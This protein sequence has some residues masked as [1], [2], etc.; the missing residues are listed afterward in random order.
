MSIRLIQATEHDIQ[1]LHLL[2]C[3]SY[4]HHFSHLWHSA[5]ELNQYLDA[6]YGLHAI[7]QSMQQ[8]NVN[9]FVIK[10]D[11]A[12][13]LVKLTFAEKLPE[14]A[15][16][17]TM[18]NKIYFLPETT[19]QGHGQAIFKEIEDLARQQGDQCIWLEVLTSNQA[20]K[21][22][23]EKCGMHLV[24]DAFFIVAYHKIPMHIMAKVL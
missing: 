1:Q 6:E 9:W 10:T 18:I 19:G 13:G 22:F 16:C 11:K 21:R 23:Y 17:G 7:Q 12:I 2:G 3:A 8:K 14:E 15:Y 5:T 24:K 20:A 4:R